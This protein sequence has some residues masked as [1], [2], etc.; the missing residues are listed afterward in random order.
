MTAARQTPRRAFIGLGSNLDS[1]HSRLIAALEAIASAPGV[2]L[3]A[4]SSLYVS[5]PVGF[6]DQPDFINAVALIETTLP[7]AELLK[8]ML[9]FEREAGRVREFRNA[10]RTLDIDILLYG[11]EQYQSAEL[12]IPHPR[13]TERAFVLKP[14]IEIAPDVVIPG[15]GLARDYLNQVAHQACKKSEDEQPQ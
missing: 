7:P 11:D 6:L 2:R 3:V 1:P 5:S 13:I 14:L 4:R 12:E 15:K 8:S 10:P 9:D